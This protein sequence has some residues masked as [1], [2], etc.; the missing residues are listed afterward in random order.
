MG[1]NVRLFA[2]ELPSDPSLSSS[3]RV[4]NMVTATFSP[5]VGWV[6]FPPFCL[7]SGFLGPG[8]GTAPPPS[9]F[10]SCSG[11]VLCAC[12]CVVLCCLVCMWR[13]MVLVTELKQPR[14]VPPRWGGGGEYRNVISDNDGNLPSF[15]TC[16]PGVV[17]GSSLVFKYLK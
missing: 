16:P 14:S 8:F 9:P 1:P 13:L 17:E 5:L 10:R 4:S 15:V 3:R 2:S 12:V 6:Q 11:V 7:H